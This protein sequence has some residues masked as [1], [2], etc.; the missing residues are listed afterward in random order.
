[1][2]Y[3]CSTRE[4]DNDYRQILSNFVEDL[5]TTINLPEW[6]ASQVLLRVLS[7]ILLKNIKK[8]SKENTVLKSFSIELLG[9]IAAKVKKEMT[10]AQKWRQILPSSSVSTL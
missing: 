6:P 1:L 10:L 8:N 5:L 3:R 9:S 2:R 7:V 4:E